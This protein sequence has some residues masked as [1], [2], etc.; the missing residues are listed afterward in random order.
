MAGAD[1]STTDNDLADYR[2]ERDEAR[3]AW[4]ANYDAALDDFT[5]GRLHEHWP[6]KIRRQREEDGRPCLTIPLLPPILRQ[7]V[8]DAR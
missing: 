7:V 8:N 5:F 1:T 3:E 6:E 4:S 2:E